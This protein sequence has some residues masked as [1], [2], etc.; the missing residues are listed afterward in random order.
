MSAYIVSEN[1]VKLV[2]I[3]AA[4]AHAERMP[5]LDK[6]TELANLL[7]V[8]NYASV[9]HRYNENDVAPTLTVKPEDVMRLRKYKLPQIIMTAHSINY[10]SCELDGWKDSH[11]FKVIREVYDRASFA[12]AS[13]L[14]AE[15]CIN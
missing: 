7:Y 6:A 8:E 3:Y 1:A 15:W 5:D 13:E 11:A 12:L 10:Q 14:G 2:A 4:T 9:N